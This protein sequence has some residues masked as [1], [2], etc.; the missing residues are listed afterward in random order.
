MDSIHDI[1]M[2]RQALK[3]AHKAFSIDEVPIGAIVV[4]NKGVILG[5]GYNKV[6]RK[7]QQ[8]AHAE[9]SAIAQACTKRSDWRLDGCWLYV[10]LQPCMMC[11][12][13]A[14]ISRVA[15]IVYGAPSPL[16]GYHLDKEGDVWLYK[17]N[18]IIRKGVC[19]QEAAALLKAFFK[20]KRKKL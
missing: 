12:G 8:I 1:P 13:L 9:V 7:K 20:P 19:A 14:V 10:T 6:E 4:D 2:M 15:G 16:F 18:I 3:Q 17:E 11:L 5:R